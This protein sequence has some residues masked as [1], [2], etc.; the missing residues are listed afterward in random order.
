VEAKFLIGIDEAGRGP[1]AGPVAVGA[2]IVPYDFD[3]SLVAD[4]RESKQLSAAARELWYARL[5]A[6]KREGAL[7]FAVSLS[8]AAVIDQ[9]GIVPAVQSSLDRALRKIAKEAALC[10]VRLDGG[11]HAPEEFADQTTI[12]RGDESE[13]VIALASIAA[14]VTRDRLMMRMGLRYPG[15]SFEVHKGY[16]T[17]AHRRAIH[18]SGLSE[19]HRASFCT[20]LQKAGNSV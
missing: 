14:K 18:A 6:L 13:P 19:I 2:V 16:G 7:D 11:L 9:R 15:Y 4:V 20:R 8:S 3:F 17:L 1:L 12:I 10:E 5:R